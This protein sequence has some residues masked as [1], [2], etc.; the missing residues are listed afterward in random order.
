MKTYI[1]SV[2]KEVCGDFE[3]EAETPKL[4]EAKALTEFLS[5]FSMNSDDWCEGHPDSLRA[6]VVE[7]LNG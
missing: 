1:V 3:I 7:R 5:D 2:C 4:A 6:V